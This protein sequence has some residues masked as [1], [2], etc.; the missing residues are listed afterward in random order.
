MQQ[1]LTVSKGFSLRPRTLEEAM[2]FAQLMANSSLVP[3]EYKGRPADIVVAVQM[4]SEVG[5]APIQALINIAVIN[6]RPSIWGDAALALVIR[7]PDCEWI[8]EKFA[9]NDTKAICTIKRKGHEA[10]TVT[11]S[12]DD[13]KKANLWGKS[14][15]WTSYPKRMLQM[16]A[17][18]FAL[19][20]KF[21][22][23]LR[24][25]IL[26]EEAMDYPTVDVQPIVPSEEV[27][28]EK[29]TEEIELVVPPVEN[30]E[31]QELRKEIERMILDIH[32][33]PTMKDLVKLWSDRQKDAIKVGMLREFEAA[34][35]KRKDE[36]VE[37]AV[38]S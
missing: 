16:R 34:K 8:E 12:V 32:K 1:E 26:Q 31:A 28:P 13:A 17:R 30:N 24:G 20:D 11:F 35:D 33:V 21:P 15:P 25:L 29:S 22:D 3:K 6:G 5:L 9:D 23:S 4:G 38:A 18:G 36:L 27:H 7:H 14:G 37:M 2:R 19:R 10:Y